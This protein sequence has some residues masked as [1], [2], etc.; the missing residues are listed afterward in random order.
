MRF[1]LARMA[2]S[3]HCTEDGR[4]RM[5][6]YRFIWVFS[7]AAL[8]ALPL[9]ACGDD[10]GSSS[11]A[12]EN[13]D[14]PGDNDNPGRTDPDDPIDDPTEPEGGWTALLLPNMVTDVQLANKGIT[15]L[16]VMAISTADDNAGEGLIGEVIRWGVETDKTS[17]S[18]G[19]TSSNTKEG[20]VAT[21]S[22][23]ALGIPGDSVVVASYPK[24]PKNVR[25]NIQVLD[26]PYGNLRVSTSYNGRAPVS[27][28]SIALYDSNDYQCGMFDPS[29]GIDAEP[30]LPTVD[31]SVANFTGLSP[32]QH[33]VVV[34]NGYSDSGA[35][36]ASGCVDYGL[37]IYE[38]QTTDALVYLETVD[39]N[40]NTTY[41]ARS[42]F[43]LGDVANNLGTVGQFVTKITD[44]ANNPAQTLY[45]LLYE[46]IKSAIGGTVSG[47]IDTILKY[48]GL[49]ENL[50]SWL[51]DQLKAN[52]TVCQVGNFACQFRSIIRTMEFMGEL[53]IQR[54]G[55]VE[56]KGQNA[57]DG[58]AIYWRI[59]CATDKNGDYID[60]NCGRMPLTTKQLNLGTTINFLEGSWNGSVANGYDKLAIEAH[61]LKLEYG[62]IA[63]YLIN[64]VLLPKLAGG[65]KNFPDALAYWI[66]CNA[67]GD[68]LSDLLTMCIGIT[69]SGD[70]KGYPLK[71]STTQ[72]TGW[73]KSATNGLG[74]LLGF[75][76]AMGELQKAGSDITISGTATFH[77]SNAD[78]R[79]DTIENGNWSGSMT[80]TLQD[81][82]GASVPKTTAVR[83]IWSAYNMLNDNIG[84]DGEIYCTYPKTETDSDDQLCAYPTIN[85]NAL[86]ASYMCK[87]YIQ[88]M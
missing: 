81:D 82:S 83:G 32:E 52:K 11:Q 65:A 27:H 29:A 42:Y 59:G 51:N 62:K 10:A 25:F 15:K 48:T 54:T 12:G 73:C 85:L 20:G 68:Y 77:D 78:N 19:A 55:S 57:Y 76:T 26:L 22:V 69:I 17:L 7:V 79:V 72:A 16:S 2:I 23:R 44:F 40:L 70:C 49:K 58:L 8:L 75:L 53:E 31:N 1:V 63:V 5:S 35:K 9:S 14:T 87:E 86:S 3:I 24:A 36:V 84:E 66:N 37:T 56:L 64:N 61:E 30:L 88:C 4:V 34:A 71:V 45:D 18:L 21:V 46:I 50:L 43:D 80:I 41:H 74:S 38:N 60:P 67:V 33:Y 13:P 39:L 47:G 28:Y 6:F